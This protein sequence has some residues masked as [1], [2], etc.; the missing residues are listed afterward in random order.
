MSLI[1]MLLMSFLF[2]QYPQSFE[3]ATTHKYG[4]KDVSGKV[5]VKPVYDIAREFEKAPYTCVNI[6]AN[7]KAN[8]GGK[9]GAIDVQGKVIIPVKYD[10]INYIGYGLFAVNIGEVFSNMDASS[11]GKFAIFNAAGKPLTPF[12]YTGS[13]YGLYFENGYVILRTTDVKTNIDK[14]GILDSTGK[15]VLP[16]QYDDINLYS[17]D[18]LILLKKDGKCGYCDL[19][20]K[21]SIPLKFEDAN[22]FQNG[23]ASVK[24]NNKW[25]FIDKTGATIIDF[26]YE[27]AGVFE[28]GYAGVKQNGKW[29]VIGKDNKPLLPFIYDKVIWV[30][31]GGNNI[32]VEKNGKYYNLNSK[33]EEIR[34]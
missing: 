24:L 21:M 12:I 1:S 16:V 10:L 14:Y 29:G 13:L 8:K 26:Q 22:I 27:D 31:D 30:K 20:L 28:E 9:W 34:K 23:M 33:G 5:I 17:S 11:E 15:I 2:A 18:G 32:R 3:D 4:Y 6:G 19:K 25:G 7:Y